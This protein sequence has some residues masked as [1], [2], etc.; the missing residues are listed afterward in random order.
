MKQAAIILSLVV[1]LFP[2]CAL[3]ESY[4]VIVRNKT[5]QT[6]TNSVCATHSRRASILEVGTTASP[7]LASLAEDGVAATYAGEL[8]DGKGIKTVQT[9]GFISGNQKSTLTL[10]G[11]RAARMSCVFGMLVVTNDGFPAALK[12]KLPRRIGSSRRF[13]ANVYDAGS[14]VNTESCSDVPGGP[15]NAHFTGQEE[16]GVIAKHPGLQGIGDIDVA[17]YGWSEPGVRGKIVRID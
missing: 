12:I 7:G 16:N 3:T 5:P 1:F 9:G 14:E 17:S 13:R 11:K 15:C 2:D 8:R 10:S 4:R 6:L